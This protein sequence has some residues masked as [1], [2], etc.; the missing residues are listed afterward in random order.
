MTVGKA[1]FYL[2]DNSTDLTAIV[3][4]RI[5]PEVAQQDAPLPYVVYNISNNEPSDTKR[6]PSKL[7][8]A[9]IEVNCYS[10]SYTEVIDMA[11]AVRAALDRVR[12]TYNGVNVQSIAYM[13]EVI[14]F[15]EGQR[16]Y[17]VSSDY[18]ARISRLDATIPSGEPVA[19]TDGD[20]SL[21]EVP[22][23]GSYTCL[24]A[25]APA[26]IFYQRAIPWENN[27]PGITGSVYWHTQN[28]TYNYTPPTNPQYIAAL[29]NDYAGTDANCLLLQPNRY[30]NYY[31]YTNDVGEQYT[32]G[33]A[34][35]LSNTSTNKRLCIDHFTGLGYYVQDAYTDIVQRTFAQGCAYAEA[36]SYAGFSDWRLVDIGTYLNSVMYNDFVNSYDGVYC[37]FVDPLIRNYGGQLWTG[38]FSK[39]NAFVF[40]NTNG[41][42]ISYTTS[43]T[44]TNH[45]LMMV[46]TMNF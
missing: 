21:H 19:V 42:T 38:T 39:D 12:G 17:N 37:P 34:E 15:D 35:S 5:Y 11:V 28:G 40:V 36:F 32:E 25:T 9:N 44:A 27:D 8:T 22:A 23:G 45:H 29:P 31:K 2:L 1:I 3:G 13:N 10:T 7:D 43:T 33:F 24:P 14:D 30:G 20:G 16:A 46:R 26:G 41:G 18:D 4:T 6:E